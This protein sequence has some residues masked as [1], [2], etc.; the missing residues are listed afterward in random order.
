MSLEAK[1]REKY[2]DELNEVDD[3]EELILDGLVGNLNE[4]SEADKLYVERFKNL[5]CLSMNFLGLTSVKN[6][7]NIPSIHVVPLTHSPHL[8]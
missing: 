1:L 6:M 5:T 4:I 7:P 8:A 2:K 3:V